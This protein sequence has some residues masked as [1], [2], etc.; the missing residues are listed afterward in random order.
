MFLIIF[1]FIFFFSYIYSF[2][3]FHLFSFHSGYFNFFIFT[4]NFKDFPYLGIW[5]KNQASPFVC[6]EPW[7]GVADHQSHNQQLTQK[8]GIIKLDGGESFESLYSVEIH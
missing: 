4:F 3:Y 7:F 8:E 1:F 6:I 5:S 2:T